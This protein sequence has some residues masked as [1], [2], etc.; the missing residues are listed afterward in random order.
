MSAATASVQPGARPEAEERRHHQ[1]VPVRLLGRYMFSDGREYPC[2]ALNISPGGIALRAPV[3]S[4]SGEKMVAYI[5]QVGRLEGS[6]ARQFED[7]MALAII[8]SR[9]KRDK[10][11]DALTWIANRHMVGLQEDRRH[12]RKTPKKSE[13]MLRLKDG[14]TYPCRIVDVS[15]SGASVVT[16]Q[17]PPLGTGVSLGRFH[18]R[19]VRHFEDGV[20]IEFMVVQ[21]PQ[22]ID[23]EFR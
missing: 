10:L 16:K 14:T 6:V 19:V 2:Q 9:F 15:M 5:D 3:L 11:A 4:E 1:R 17:R 7:G 22:V 8:A 13:A 20:A 12:E 23:R 21:P 18:G